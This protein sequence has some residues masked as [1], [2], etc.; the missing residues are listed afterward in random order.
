MKSLSTAGL[1][2][3]L[4]APGL[5]AVDTR[6]SA[7]TVS[8]A[9]SPALV[10]EARVEL[11]LNSLT[12]LPLLFTGAAADDDVIFVTVTLLRSMSLPS[13]SRSSTGPLLVV[14]EFVLD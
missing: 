8:S 13:A 5:L 6:G 14:V 12:L 11:T 1:A 10:T 4:D 3:T 2:T 7:S 9:V